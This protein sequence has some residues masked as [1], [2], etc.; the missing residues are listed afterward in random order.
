MR[1]SEIEFAP[2]RTPVSDR[3]L[4][5]RYLN[6]TTKQC[7]RVKRQVRNHGPVS[8]GYLEAKLI[9]R[10][11]LAG[12]DCNNT[13]PVIADF[14]HRRFS[15]NDRFIPHDRHRIDRVALHDHVAS[16]TMFDVKHLTLRVA[17]LQVLETQS[18]IR[19]DAI[20]IDMASTG[21]ETE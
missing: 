11:R 8:S 21:H 10:S 14:V 3:L 20:V 18:K 13:E 6:V 7:Y 17:I 16:S 4:R 15:Q 9:L 1:N 2:R 5:L 19:S 12:V